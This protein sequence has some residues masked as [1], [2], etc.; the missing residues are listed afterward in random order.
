MAD[1]S[2][3]NL[4]MACKP[5]LPSSEDRLSRGYRVLHNQEAKYTGVALQ[6]VHQPIE[7]WY[8]YLSLFD[9]ALRSE[10]DSSSRPGSQERHSWE[11]RI[12][13]TATEMNT[14][15]LALDAALA[16]YYVQ[17]LGLIRRILES[18]R[19]MVFARAR[20][21]LAR[22]WL[23]PNNK[24]K[25]E[26]PDDGK[27]I[28]EVQK[29]AS[30]T[31]KPLHRNLETVNRLIVRCHKGAHPSERSFETMETRSSEHTHI[32]ATFNEHLLLEVLNIGCAALALVLG[33]IRVDLQ[34]SKEWARDLRTVNE[35]F[36]RWYQES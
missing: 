33:E 21:D 23:Q 8:Q 18:W 10:H 14:A 11:L 27:I 19:L 1:D 2:P 13:I 6:Q 5:V 36:S 7:I 32:G 17:A 29:Y 20:P 28:R 3:T 24:G 9:A 4:D 12:R 35:L 22:Q 30:K 25:Y 31:D 15:K 16:G 34:L 26:T